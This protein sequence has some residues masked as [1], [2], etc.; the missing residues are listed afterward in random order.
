MN[1]FE[2]LICQRHTALS[3]RQQGV[4]IVFAIENV[5]KETITLASQDER[6]AKNNKIWISKDYDTYIDNYTKNELFY[7]N[8][9]YATEEQ[10]Y[11]Y[12]STGN[13]NNHSRV[14]SN[15]F[16]PIINLPSLPERS[17][18]H[19]SENI[20]VQLPDNG[21]KFFI[22]PDDDDSV[23]GPFTIRRE[24]IDVDSIP[25]FEAVNSTT[26]LGLQPYY[27]IKLKKQ[28]LNDLSLSIDFSSEIEAQ[29]SFIRNLSTIKA[30]GNYESVDF[31]S[32][33]NLVSYFLRS[34][35]FLEL[36]VNKSTISTIKSYM[37]KIARNGSITKLYKDRYER[38]PQLIGELLDKNPESAIVNNYFNTEAGKH[39]ITNYLEENKNRLLKD[40]ITEIKAKNEVE[41]RQLEVQHQNQLASINQRYAQERSSVEEKITELLQNFETKKKEMESKTEEISTQN[42]NAEIEQLQKKLDEIT[43]DLE[44]KVDILDL[45]NANTKLQDDYSY[46]NRRNDELK[47]DVDK[48]QS[49]YDNLINQINDPK[50][51]TEEVLKHQTLSRIIQGKSNT[52]SKIIMDLAPLPI[53]SFHV[54]GETRSSYI[55]S[56]KELINANCERLLSYDE[57]ANILLTTMQSYLTFFNG[58]PGVG[59][60]STAF[61]MAKALGLTSENNKNGNLLTIPV[62]R[63]WTSSKDLLGFYNGMRS[64][65][66]PSRTQLYS[67][68]KAINDSRME[69]GDMKNHELLQVVLLDEANLSPIEHYWSDFLTICDRFQEENELSLGGGL[70]DQHNLLLPQSLR[71][72]ATINNDSTVEP[73]SDRLLDRAAVINFDSRQNM[74]AFNLASSELINGAVPYKE[75][76]E[77][78]IPTKKLMQQINNDTDKLSDEK[79][80]LETF[81]AVLQKDLP[82]ALPV[83]ISPRKHQTILRYCAVAKDLKLQNTSAIDFA[84]SQ[85]ILPKVKGHGDGFFARLTEFQKVA[86]TTTQLANTKSLLNKIIERGSD[87]MMDYSL[88]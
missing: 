17:S 26:P 22:S 23:Y 86:H 30:L 76:A 24:N 49:A 14:E 64:H 18:G 36:S 59:K 39:H 6:F 8:G 82:K 80:I 58:A 33:A 48:T 25:I 74:D 69:E 50:I 20:A 71:F 15:N 3:A 1:D 44:S 88:L 38:L 12:F 54:V 77:A 27:V 19:L 87:S 35:L 29:G 9:F 7:L 68:L 65:Y 46:Y 72:I 47:N 34:E 40:Q 41:V 66:Q 45:F 11:D 31:I 52:K 56:I 85:H 42:T 16:L 43:I 70:S 2:R 62:S 83:F 75:L 10:G 84:I 5:N 32:N 51:L 61:N 55:N 57:T 63:G 4:V 13:A 21:V 78:F 60:T 37:E 79:N 73:I 67:F 53:S 81:Y 28:H